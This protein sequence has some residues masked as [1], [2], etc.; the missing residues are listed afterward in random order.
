[1]KPD[2]LY[3]QTL[4]CECG[5]THQILPREVVYASDATGRL[6]EVCRRAAEGRRVAVL[7]DVRTGEVAGE[8]AA[9]AL[10]QDGWTVRALLVPDGP[11]GRWPACDDVTRDRLVERLD[12][13]D[14][15]VP[16]GSGVMTDLAKWLADPASLPYVPFAT[17]ASMNAYASSNIAPAVEGVK[18]VVYS[19]PPA[20]VVSSPQILADAPYEMTVAGLGDVLAKSVSSPDW[21][22]NGELFGDYYC[23]RSVGLVADLEPRYLGRPEDIRARKGEAIEALFQ[24]LLLT[25]VAMTMA[26]TSSPAS[27]A[28]HLI[29]HSL[30]MLAAAEGTE[31]DLHGRQVG[32]GTVLTCELYRRVL[33]VESPTFVQTATEV[34]RSFWGPLADGV[35]DEYEQKLPRMAA[36]R[37]KLQRGGVWDDLRSKLAGI[38]RPPERVRDCLTRAGGATTAEHVGTDRTRLLEVFRRCNQIRARFTVLDLAMLIGVMPG[39]AAEIVDGWA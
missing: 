34:D 9:E 19:Q 18:R 24:A 37:E 38:V 3:G 27:G 12:K 32:L 2:E 35:A 39:A 30:D 14:L 13:V 22:L 28:E 26:Q 21:Y 15:F 20:A 25:G 36:A 4:E 1:M 17:A 7:Y 11:A 5:R 29:S 8:A 31:H 23:S 33:A 16:V 10:R 6:P